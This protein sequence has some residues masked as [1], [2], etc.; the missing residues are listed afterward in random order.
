M[1][2]I[3]ISAFRACSAGCFYAG[4]E[5]KIRNFIMTGLFFSL[6]RR[7]LFSDLGARICCKS[8]LA[9][10]GW[11]ESESNFAI[12]YAYSA[13]RSFGFKLKFRAGEFFLIRRLNECV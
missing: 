2:E 12:V 9:N 13:F 7:P 4:L 10:M 1:S 6:H 5:V 11:L 8:D 3:R